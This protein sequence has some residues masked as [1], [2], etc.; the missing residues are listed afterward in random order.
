MNQE[1]TW[2]EENHYHVIN[3]LTCANNQMFIEN[4]KNDSKYTP[5]NSVKFMSHAIRKS[6]SIILNQ[7]PS[8]ANYTTEHTIFYDL[9]TE[10]EHKM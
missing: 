9:P 2:D 8:E 6:L 5:M 4:S 10:Q 3:I 1:S 7:W